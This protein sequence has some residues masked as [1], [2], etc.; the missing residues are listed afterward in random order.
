MVLKS[1]IMSMA[2][3]SAKDDAWSWTLPRVGIQCLPEEEVRSVIGEN[4]ED[5]WLRSSL[6]RS[7]SSQDVHSSCG[8]VTLAAAG[9]SR[10]G[11]G[12]SQRVRLEDW[13]L[14]PQ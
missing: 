14:A 4:G 12:L 8:L 2:C 5:T 3:C 9:V 7:S 6:G 11:K 1:D 10:Q 13:L